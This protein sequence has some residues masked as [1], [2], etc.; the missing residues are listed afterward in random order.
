MRSSLSDRG[1]GQ[2]YTWGGEVRQEQQSGDGGHSHLL[3]AQDLL[4]QTTQQ[5]WAKRSVPSTLA[6]LP[7]GILSGQKEPRND[8]GWTEGPVGGRC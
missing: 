7:G 8:L 3:A 1:G 4:S 2:G 5:T 6:E